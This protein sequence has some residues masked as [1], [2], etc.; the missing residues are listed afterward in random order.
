MAKFVSVLIWVIGFNLLMEYPCAFESYPYDS[1]EKRVDHAC[2][3][4]ISLEGSLQNAAWSPCGDAIVFTRFKG[5]YNRGPA[6]LVLYNLKSKVTKTL[7]SDNSDNI[8]L[9]GAA[10]NALRQQ[11]VFSSSREPHDEIFVISE[12]GKSGDE[13]KITGRK[14]RV[15]YE[16][17]FSP[18]GNW[19][20]FESHLLDVEENGIITKYKIDQTGPYHILTGTNEDCRQPNG[21]PDGRHIVYQRLDN[22]QWD[23]WVMDTCGKNKRQITRGAG[24][25]TDASFSP[26][27]QWIA[28]SADGPTL[29]FANLYIIPVSDGDPVQVTHFDGYDGAPSWSP[30]GR[31][32]VFESSPGDPDDSYGTLIWLIDVSSKSAIMH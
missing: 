8:N 21:S 30:D 26:D 4:K 31:K 27:S 17:S 24:D 10:W 12:A 18:D 19:V 6:D 7:V 13:K 2:K 3:L 20:V 23:L 5:G 14:N 11:I 16:P 25:K 22:G 1:N 32:I 28:Y 15:A 9:P 29:K